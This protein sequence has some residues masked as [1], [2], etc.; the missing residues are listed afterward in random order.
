MQWRAAVGGIVCL[1]FVSTVTATTNVTEAVPL[2]AIPAI[3]DLFK[4]YQVVGLGE[5]PHG[6][7]EGHA[8]RLKLVRDPRFPTIVN[9]ILV[10][11]G[12]A[13]YQESMDRFI[14][15][16]SVPRQELRR[17]W[18]DTTNP[19]TNWDKPMYEEFFTAVRN[20]N[21]KLPDDRKLRVLLGDP[22]IAWEAIH[23]RSDL[24]RWN[25]QRDLHAAAALKRES[26]AKGRKVLAV[27]GDGHF[28][29]RGFK[30]NSLVN[31]VERATVK[32]FTISTRYGDLIMMQPS[33]ASWQ[34]PA[35]AFLKGT[36][37]GKKYYAQYYPMPPAAGW[38]T[39]LMED[40]FD[41]VLYLSPKPPTMTL[42][43]ANLCRDAA[44]LKMRLAR[45]AVTSGTQGSSD[46][47]GSLQKLCGDLTR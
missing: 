39:V 32:M 8:F 31:L 30:A 37:L 6:N 34:A 13:R 24:R 20:V 19:G 10:E 18:E 27:Y 47:A 26:F 11:S 35:F 2:P 1:A 9:D 42:I 36:V 33:V 44:Y 45:L 43:P 40:Q 41:G 22:P 28:Q 29:G 5:G 15:G 21:A 7:L 12:T 46:P 17:A 4:S 14:R 25:M 16:E 23:N 38:N 3:L